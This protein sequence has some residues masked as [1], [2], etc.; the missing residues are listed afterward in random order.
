M[1]TKQIT[2]KRFDGGISDDIREPSSNKFSITKHFDIYSNPYR[3]TPYRDT[4]ADQ[5]GQVSVGKFL[6][7]VD[8][9]TSPP[10]QYV[11]GLG[12]KTGQNYPTVYYKT[13]ATLV[14]DDWVTTANWTGTIGSVN[15]ELFIEYLTATSGHAYHFIYFWANTQ[16]C[17][18]FMPASAGAMAETVSAVTTTQR[19]QGVVHSASNKLYIPYSTTSGTFI[20]Y[21]SEETF[22]S[23]CG[24]II[25]K[26]LVITSVC[27]YGNY[28]AISLRDLGGGN[29]KVFL[30]DVINVPVK[31]T[32]I[33]DWGNDDLY[34]LNN[35][36]GSLIGISQNPSSVFSLVNSK[37]TIKRWSGGLPTVIK[38]LFATGSNTVT[39]YQNVNFINNNKLFFA[40]K[41]GSTNIGIWT[42]GRKSASYNYAVTFDR[43]VTNDNSE[44]TYSDVF[45]K[46]DVMWAAQAVGTI[47][48]TNDQ[49]SYTATSI[50]ESQKFS[51]FPLAQ[52]EEVRLDYPALTTGMAVHLKCRV[53]NETLWRR[54]FK[55]SYDA[56][57]IADGTVKHIASMI[58]TPHDPT[59]NSN[60]DIVTMTSA[61]PCVVTLTNHGLVTNQPFQFAT[62]G[63]LYTGITAGTTYYVLSTSLATDTFRFSASVGGSAVNTSGSQS[64]VHTL[65]RDASLPE[66][67]EI[68]FRIESTGGTEVT[69]LSFTYSSKEPQHG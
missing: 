48:R 15:Y 3:L 41:L 5:T 21:V 45:L 55:K 38:E 35:L 42:I 43:F 61:S 67:K 39:I 14:T 37:I 23:D 16:L 8:N 47:T 64:G 1:Q 36:E 63:A 59:D 20:G 19:C 6:L 69:G 49:S 25:P 57:D 10:T 62:T 65:I 31:P 18:I 4:E 32:E 7:G 56:D 40:A 13:G 51:D 24:L 34:V 66:Y 53:D 30:W 2:L 28:L 11:L 50:Y 12:K 68:Q 33:I 54:I 44:T 27:E 58:E 9:Q 46:G 29:S 26:N 60:L 52:L 22:Y 17:R